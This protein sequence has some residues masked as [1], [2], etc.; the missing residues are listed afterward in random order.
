M[1]LTIFSL[2][3]CST[4][5]LCSV[6]AFSRYTHTQHYI[7]IHSSAQQPS[8]FKK[9]SLPAAQPI[10]ATQPG[11]P[12]QQPNPQPSSAAQPRRSSQPS[13][14]VQQLVPCKLCSELRS[15][16]ESDG[17]ASEFLCRNSGI[18]L[19]L[20]S[21]APDR[22]VVSAGDCHCRQHSKVLDIMAKLQNT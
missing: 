16:L 13:N 11:N 17:R 5:L 6:T 15:S 2:S 8:I 12:A 3:S 7:N 4:L 20:K 18:H 1:K 9:S 21:G 22:N 19:F 14:P 10:P